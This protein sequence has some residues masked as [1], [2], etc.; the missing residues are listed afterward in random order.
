MAGQ[1]LIPDILEGLL[2][3]AKSDPDTKKIRIKCLIGEQGLLCWGG[4]LSLCFQNI[5]FP[6]G[7]I[8]TVLSGGFTQEGAVCLGLAAA[9]G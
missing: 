6:W 3:P 8:R 9:A 1:G 2:S 5:L 7:L 4:Q